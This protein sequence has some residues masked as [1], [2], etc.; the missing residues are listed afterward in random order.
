MH[1]NA[2]LAR[3]LRAFSETNVIDPGSEREARKKGLLAPNHD[4]SGL[5]LTPKGLDFLSKWK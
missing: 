5:V 1:V 4:G 2:E 3:T